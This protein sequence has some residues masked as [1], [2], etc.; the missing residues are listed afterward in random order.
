MLGMEK[1]IPVPHLGAS[2]PEAEENCAVMAVK[3]LKD[4]L[5]NGNIV[6][7]VN[8]P[9]CEMPKSGNTRLVIANKNVPM[10]IG[11]ITTILAEKKINISDMLNRHKGDVA[12]NII[13]V[14]GD[15]DAAALEKIK[16]IDGII[17]A[18]LV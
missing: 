13:D 12:Y 6:N 5:E 11:Q 4:F 17:M 8:F 18:R 9:N 2:T 1:V 16:K 3:Q 15:I 10:M 14:E 7:S